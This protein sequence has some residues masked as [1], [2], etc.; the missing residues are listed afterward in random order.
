MTKNFQDK[1]LA[2]LK[3]Q[4]ITPKP[5]W[6][7]LLKDSIIW[8]SAGCIILLGALATATSIAIITMH[9]LDIAEKLEHSKA[10]FIIISLPY[11]WILLIM[12]F[13]FIAEYNIR[14]TKQGYKYTLPLLAGSVI[15]LSFV[16]G[17][18]LYT[19]GI[20]HRVDD[21][22]SQHMPAYETYGNRRA[23][24][25]HNPNQGVLAG[26]IISQD[27][28]TWQLIDI[29][30]QTWLVD[31]ED[32]EILGKEHILTGKPVRIVGEQK[33]DH[34]FEAEQILPMRPPRNFNR[35]EHKPTKNRR[36]PISPSDQ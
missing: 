36:P 14:H 19:I 31:V 7:F 25:L 35:N 26:K 8:I 11:A 30:L 16:G 17:I 24:H 22:M 13:I 27:E 32:A 12:L 23:I 2:A 29:T 15:V 34:H 33:D 9:D 10:G 18:L 3:K 28:D 1:I 5:K 4:D 21:I 6:T 20:G